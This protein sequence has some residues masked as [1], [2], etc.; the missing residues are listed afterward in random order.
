M[1]NGSNGTP[2]LRSRFVV[3]AGSVYNVNG[4]GGSANAVVVSHSHSITD[5]GHTHI[6]NKWVSDNA[7]DGPDS[8]TRFSGDIHL[9][10]QPTASATTGISVNSAGQSG[11]DANLPPY[12]AL[13]YIMKTA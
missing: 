9:Q 11:I 4:T 5:P 7:I 2:D 13:A 10:I 12:Y 8:T 6:Y 3:G 1:C